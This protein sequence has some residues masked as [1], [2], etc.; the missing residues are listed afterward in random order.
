MLSCVY[1]VS[2]V[3]SPIHLCLSVYGGQVIKTIC[4]VIYVKGPYCGSNIIGPDQTPR[5]MRGVSS[6]PTIFV[7]N[8]H[9]KETFFSLPAQFS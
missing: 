4:D 8:G 2:P 7:A 9:L 3:C 1:A 5:M 6:G